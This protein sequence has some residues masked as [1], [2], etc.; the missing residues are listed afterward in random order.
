MPPT[1]EEIDRT[2]K[3]A[4]PKI[5]DAVK[6]GI[7]EWRRDSVRSLPHLNSATIAAMINCYVQKNLSEFSARSEGFYTMIEQR[8]FSLIYKDQ[9]ALRPKKVK[10]NLRSCNITTHRINAIRKQEYFLPGI[11]CGPFFL[12]LGYRLTPFYELD[13]V[14]LVMEDEYSAVWNI[15][16]DNSVVPKQQGAFPLWQTEPELSTADQKRA[17]VRAKS[18]QTS[19]NAKEA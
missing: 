9:F 6:Q 13:G 2:F 11:G 18:V 7:A 15:R 1:K 17:R 4:Y 14:F 8:G 12:T 3:D 16:I 10:R 5:I 19:Q